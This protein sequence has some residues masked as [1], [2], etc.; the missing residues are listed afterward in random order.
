MFVRDIQRKAR[1][2]L[3]ETRG[4][5]AVAFAASLPVLVGFTALAAD[6]GHVYLQEEKLRQLTETVALAALLEVRNEKY[7]GFNG[8][9]DKFKSGLVT[10]AKTNM[11][12]VAAISAI[13]EEDIEFGTWDFHK[14]VFSPNTPDTPITAVRVKGYMNTER[15]NQLPSFFGKLF[16]D[17]FD[18]STESIAVLPVPP[19]FHTL[20][21]TASRA[22]TIENGDVDTLRAVV[23][24]TADD[25]LW[26]PGNGQTSLGTWHFHVAG[27]FK[28]SYK[29][30]R[31]AARK[32]KTNVSGIRDFLEDQPSP[33]T[34][35]CIPWEYV[36]R[37]LYNKIVV[38]PGIYCGGLKISVPTAKVEFK[39]GTYVFKDGPLVIENQGEVFGDRVHLFMTGKKSGLEIRNS[40]VRFRA[41]KT[42]QYAGMV[43]MSDRS[44]DHAPERLL[45]E[46]SNLAFVGTIYAPRSK[47]DV[48]KT[49]FNTSCRFICVV[50]DTM[51]FRSTYINSYHGYKLPHYTFPGG[52]DIPAPVGLVSSFRPYLVE[53]IDLPVNPQEAS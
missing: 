35:S 21:K 8:R 42:G 25:A 24:S 33:V 32:V 44:A 23:N 2:F 18:I 9:A 43:I 41:Q 36:P 15:G 13:K 5:A 22:M 12:A 27:D 14:R 28:G 40:A 50:A 4:S 49:H 3:S 31:E 37:P 1:N 46:R 53:Q 29:G 26:M 10:F 38:W 20:S 16:T 30:K 6:V 7:Y 51:A 48:D 47:L 11:H 19:D 17:K 34:N 39:P 52:N 45:I